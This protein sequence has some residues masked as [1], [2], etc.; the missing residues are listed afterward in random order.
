MEKQVQ[1]CWALGYQAQ[2]RGGTKNEDPYSI[3][4]YQQ[5]ALL[6]PSPSYLRTKKKLLYLQ[7]KKECYNKEYS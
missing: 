3:L 6:T 5:P 2:G 4:E 7:N 1:R